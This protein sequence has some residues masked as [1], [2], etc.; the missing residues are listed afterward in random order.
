MLKGNCAIKPRLKRSRFNVKLLAI[1]FG[2][3]VETWAQPR[4][5]TDLGRRVCTYAYRAFPSVDL[6]E[7]VILKKVLMR[8]NSNYIC[9][10]NLLLWRT[11]TRIHLL[12]RSFRLSRHENIAECSLSIL[13]CPIRSMSRLNNYDISLG[14]RAADDQLF[15]QPTAIRVP[16]SAHISLKRSPCCAWISSTAR[17]TL[18][19]IA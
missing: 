14:Q 15:S 18:S 16:S 11:V 10:Q 5:W 7:R 8:S 2:T 13:H 4:R 3:A 1:S 19:I 6:A 17:E 9:C 12:G